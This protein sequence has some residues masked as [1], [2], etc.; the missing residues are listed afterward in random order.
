MRIKELEKVEKIKKQEKLMALVPVV[1]PRHDKWQTIQGHMFSQN[2]AEWRLAIIEADTIL[3][4]MTINIGLPGDTLGDRLKNT[5]PADFKNVQA[6][7]EAHKTRN[8][9]AHDGSNFELTQAEANRIMRMYEDVFNE[10]N[11]I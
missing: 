4:E 7:W 5:S 1:A 11:Y 10:F 2:P 6:A 8:R 9:I 3:E